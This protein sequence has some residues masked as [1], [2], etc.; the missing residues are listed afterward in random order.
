MDIM[1]KP[2]RQ[3]RSIIKNGFRGL[4]RNKGA[5]FLSTASITAVLLL[6]GIVLLVV[7][8]MSNIVEQSIK[9]FD[10]IVVFL[11]DDFTVDQYEAIVEGIKDKDYSSN[12]TFTDKEQAMENAREMFKDDGY[13]LNGLKTNPFPASLNIELKS[14]DQADEVVNELANYQ[15][16]D[17]INYHKAA[18]DKMITVDRF[19]KIGGTVLVLILIVV[20]IFIISNT[21]KMA[22]SARSSEV[23][24]MRYIGATD[25][26]IKGPFI[27]EGMT[28][29][30]MAAIISCVIMFI[31][32]NVFYQNLNMA[33]YDFISVS[34]V[35]PK[36]LY[37]DVSIIFVAIGLGVGALGSLLSL[38]RYL[39]A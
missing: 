21:I 17:K 33:L 32:Y 1:I 37:L 23:E 11:V 6:L 10:Q 4:T 18:I 7:I 25:S 8:N 14:I 38:R 24:I 31:A 39:K 9:T 15:G 26:F 22:V 30:V 2:L 35:T 28:F 27:F 20:T 34:L 29:G 16:I 13:I 12:I 5:G 3:I 19:T 36:Q